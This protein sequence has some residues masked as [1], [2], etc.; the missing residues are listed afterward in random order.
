VIQ[1]KATGPGGRPCG[2]LLMSAAS[3]SSNRIN[4]KDLRGC[5]IEHVRLCVYI[6]GGLS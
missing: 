2:F 3:W 5:G 6:S 4:I 1:I